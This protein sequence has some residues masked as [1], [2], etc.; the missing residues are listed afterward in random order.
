VRESKLSTRSNCRS[1]FELRDYFSQ[2]NSSSMPTGTGLNK[3]NSSNPRSAFSAD[4][5]VCWR[6]P[7]TTSTRSRTNH[8]KLALTLTQYSTTRNRPGLPKN[9][10]KSFYTSTNAH[11][12]E[13]RVTSGAQISEVE[14]PVGRNRTADYLISVLQ[15]DALP[16][17]LPPARPLIKSEDKRLR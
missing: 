11:H 16:T 12:H 5:R 3:T 9:V 17:E 14:I 1:L 7:A 10:C 6:G 15:S 4:S 8:Y 2:S 13:Q